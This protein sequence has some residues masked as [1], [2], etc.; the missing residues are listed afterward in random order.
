MSIVGA[1]WGE[2]RLLASLPDLLHALGGPRLV[3][4]VSVIPDWSYQRVA[5]VVALSPFAILGCYPDPARP[6]ALCPRR[7]G[8]RGTDTRGRGT[9]RRACTD[10][11]R[12]LSPGGVDPAGSV[13]RVAPPA[14]V[15]GPRGGVGPEGGCSTGTGRCRRRPSGAS[16]QV[17]PKPSSTARRPHAQAGGEQRRRPGGVADVAV[18]RRSVNHRH[19]A[20]ASRVVGGRAR[21]GRCPARAD[22]EDLRRWP[23]WFGLE[24]AHRGYQRPDD[25]ADIDE[26]AALPAVAVDEQRRAAPTRSAKPR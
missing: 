16:R 20:T 15:Q 11:R 14:D 7:T 24:A 21:H 13:W 2:A 4:A 25:V 5:P 22:V 9:A 12:G 3:P 23:G 19:R 1:L 8:G 26:V 10:A 17:R 6:P 18:P